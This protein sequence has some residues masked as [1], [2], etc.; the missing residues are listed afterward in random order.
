MYSYSVFAAT[1]VGEG[2]AFNGTFLTGEDSEWIK[3]TELIKV[4]F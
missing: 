1:S 3:Y 2:P 4:L